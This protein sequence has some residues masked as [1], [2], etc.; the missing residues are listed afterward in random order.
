MSSPTVVI[1]SVELEKLKQKARACKKSEGISHQDA[2]E[3]VAQEHGFPHWHAVTKIA[4]HW[5]SA[6]QE[7]RAG[8]LVVVD[9]KEA[10]LIEPRG[11]PI[12]PFREANGPEIWVIAHWIRNSTCECAAETLPLIGRPLDQEDLEYASNFRFYWIEPAPTSLEEVDQ[13]V[14]AATRWSPHLIC[15][16]G[17]WRGGGSNLMTGEDGEVIGVRI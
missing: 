6:D 9:V 14:R 2:L 1:T 13:I 8:V 5:E 17:A 15:F 7:L 11:E 16:R 10:Q 12:P 3:R 4:E